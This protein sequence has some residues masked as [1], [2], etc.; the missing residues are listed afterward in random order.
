ML[1][2]LTGL[3]VFAKVAA[4]GSDAFGLNC[5]N[6]GTTASAGVNVTAQ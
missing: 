5:L 3:E 2:R 4:A 6:A 1:D